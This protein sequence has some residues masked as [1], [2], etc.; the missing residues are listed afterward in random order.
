VQAAEIMCF[1]IIMLHKQSIRG[2]DLAENK[3]WTWPKF[4]FA[5]AVQKKKRRKEKRKESAHA[6]IRK[7]KTGADFKKY[8][9]LLLALGNDT[10]NI[11]THTL[12]THIL[13][14]VISFHQLPNVKLRNYEEC[15]PS[16]TMAYLNSL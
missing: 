7:F 9:A 12:N 15:H 4:K 14:T 5:S 8:F 1:V 3:E 13:N 6:Q 10:Y 2:L 16:L 11:H